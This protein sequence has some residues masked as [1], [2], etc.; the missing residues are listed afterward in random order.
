MPPLLQRRA[1]AAFPLNQ[2]DRSTLPVLTVA[3]ENA[4]VDPP[5]LTPTRGT[6]E[7]RT[8]HAMLDQ[9]RP[10]IMGTARPNTH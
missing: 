2:G 1:G 6:R 7:L 8:S 9:P 5:N 10:S 3:E 4:T